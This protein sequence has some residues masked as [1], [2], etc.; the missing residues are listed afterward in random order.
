M[1][2][3]L[4]SRAI[5]IKVESV[6]GKAD[7][8]AEPG[9]GA[10]GGIPPVPGREAK[11]MVLN[12]FKVRLVMAVAGVVVLGGYLAAGGSF[13]R[14]SSLVIEFGMYPR[15][16]TGCQVEIDGRVA[17]TLEPFGQA[18]RKAF[19]VKDGEH[20]VRVLHPKFASTPRTVITGA[21]ASPVMLILD[22]GEMVDAS[23]NSEVTLYFQ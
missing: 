10:G 16:F 1:E 4:F 13:G 19:P 7:R 22:L 11:L 17:G 18:T 6:I 14:K 5:E 23:G 15:E 12:I 9:T 20:T 3:V 2:G 21:G 8:G